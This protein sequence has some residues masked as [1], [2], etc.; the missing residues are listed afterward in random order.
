MSVRRAL[1]GVGPTARRRALL[2]GVDRE[3]SLPQL[4]PGAA[5]RALSEIEALRTP[6]PRRRR[7]SSPARSEPERPLRTWGI[8][9]G[10]A[11]VVFL[12]LLA[13]L[14]VLSMA[15]STRPSL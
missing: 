8:V 9:I 11:A 3:P 6:S 10:V 1:P 2:Q 7:P 13:L 12:L 15:T 14:Y 4:A 5:A